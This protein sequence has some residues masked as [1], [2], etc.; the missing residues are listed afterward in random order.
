MV[1]ADTLLSF[2]N[3]EESFSEFL[4]GLKNSSQFTVFSDEYTKLL[5]YFDVENS[6]LHN[7]DQ[8]TEINFEYF[9][10]EINEYVLY[11]IYNQTVTI[12]QDD[13]YNI[14]WE[15]ERIDYDFEIVLSSPSDK[16]NFSKISINDTESRIE[17]FYSE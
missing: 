4:N 1:G 2:Y 15:S 9:D 17:V 14:K 10:E 6:F 3:E 7:V 5:L 12:N 13:F 16:F 8:Y 11:P